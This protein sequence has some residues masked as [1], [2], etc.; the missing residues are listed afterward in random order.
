VNDDDKTAKLS[1]SVIETHKNKGLSQSDIARMYGVS[2]QAVSWH[3]R[4]YGGRLTP[5]EKV[6]EH[7]P[8][9]V[10][11][12]MGYTSPFKRLR[13]HGEYVATGRVG[14]SKD[15]LQRLRA[16]YRKLREE[17]LVCS[18]STRIFRQFPV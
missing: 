6:L 14:M 17:G 13:D 18:N 1:L 8:F 2:R 16:L 4:H 10:P 7:F 15:K 9:E 5:R 11:T 3:K 12:D